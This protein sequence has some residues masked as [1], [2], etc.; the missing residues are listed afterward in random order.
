MS[1][2]L[3]SLPPVARHGYLEKLSLGLL[4]QDDPFAQSDKFSDDMSYTASCGIWPHTF[5]ER[6][7]V[8]TRQQLL[9]WKSMDAYNYYQ[10]GYVPNT[11]LWAPLKA[12]LCIV[13]AKVN[14]NQSSPDSSHF[15]WV[16]V[17]SDGQVITGHCTC[18]TG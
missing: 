6:P 11:E 5:I 16:V 18:M 8:Y 2:Y 17:K 14:P 7:G 15:V 4:E 12:L 13:R 1:D 3:C 10:S 9:Q